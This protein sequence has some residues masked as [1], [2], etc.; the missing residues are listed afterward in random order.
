MTPVRK[1]SFFDGLCLLNRV[2]LLSCW[3]FITINHSFA[4]CVTSSAPNCP[5]SGS[6][7]L[8]DTYPAAAHVIS[9]FPTH[10]TET[11]RQLPADFV[12]SILESY[13][14]QESAPPIIIP[15]RRIQYDELVTNLRARIAASN[16]RIPSSI[17]DKVI[18]TDAGNYTWQQDY[19]ESFFDPQTGRPV[20]REIASYYLA[21]ESSASS[22]TAVGRQLSCGVS[23]GPRLASFL[24]PAPR[25][26]RSFG[27]GEMGGN[28]EGLPGGLCLIGNNQS[29]QFAQQF[30]GS[31]ENTVQID[32][33]WLT[34]G[35]V[36]ELVKV[37]P[38]RY[39][40]APSE[41]NFSIMLAS[42]AKA[43]ELLSTPSSLNQPFLLP[44]FL[45][46]SSSEDQ[47]SAFRYSRTRKDPGDVMCDLFFNYIQFSRPAVQDSS[48]GPRGTQAFFQKL[49]LN[50][51]DSAF[52]EKVIGEGSGAPSLRDMA[53]CERNIDSITNL[54]FRNAFNRSPTLVEYNRLVQENMNA[55][56]REILDRVFARLPQCRSF[57]KVVK[58]PDLFYGDAMENHDGSFSLP[59][60]GNGGSLLPNPT[61]SVVSN[62]TI[63][64]PDPQNTIFRD[65]LQRESSSLGLRSNFLDT[66]DY[67]HM[68]GGNLHCSSHTIPYCN[69]SR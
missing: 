68:G 54:E 39:P 31:A 22:L 62:D 10:L 44:T 51:I 50:I 25:A 56:E 3:I 36:D 11:S 61:N 2:V 58:V 37:V 69:P 30:C 60:R 59:I 17:L 1:V 67:A 43:L 32:T 38:A 46:A 18:F 27:S 28:I 66:W 42:P 33:S 63:I 52:A 16:G 47:R 55:I 6:T 65:Y 26:G 4:Q 53:T 49:S 23:E 19:F 34:V 41:C 5:T 9:I 64:Y 24:E 29:I 48:G 7:L 45:N 35:H 13:N 8:N 14:F 15:S 20:L 57:V 12:L 40:G 21:Y